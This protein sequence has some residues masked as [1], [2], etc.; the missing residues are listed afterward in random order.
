MDRSGAWTH[1][2]RSCHGI[3]WGWPHV[4]RATPAAEQAAGEG[5]LQARIDWSYMFWFT[6]ER[7]PRPLAKLH[8][9]LRLA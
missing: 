6:A 1:P 4:D 2:C 9:L 7:D 8:N 5:D 3:Q